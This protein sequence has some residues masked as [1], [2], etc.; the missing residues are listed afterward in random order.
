MCAANAGS[1]LIYGSGMLDS[2]LIFS[3]AQ[4]VIDNDIFKMVRKVMQGIHVSDET[5]ALE[6]IKSVG[7]GGDHLMQDHT[8]K[9]MRSLPSAPHII[10]RNNYQG[11]LSKGGS[12]M[13]ERAAEKAAEILANHTPTPLTD[14]ATSA[15]RTIVEDATAE[16]EEMNKK[17]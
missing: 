1:N 12:S 5:L 11:W 2:G 10:D 17:K 14:E 3:Y 4:L 8:M 6:S 9:Y 7:I 16:A 15:L 13:A